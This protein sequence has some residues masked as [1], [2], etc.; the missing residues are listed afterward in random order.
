MVVSTA[1]FGFG[2][3]G[4]YLALRSQKKNQNIRTNLALLSLA[5]A[6]S[7]FITFYVINNVPFQ[8]WQ[9]HEDPMQFA[10]LAVWY[11]ALVFPFFLAGLTVAKILSHYKDHCSQLYGVDL[12]GAA[13]GSLLMVPLIS[14]IGGE[15]ITNK[16]RI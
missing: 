9:F 8:M 3:S 14:Q 16:T 6:A 5:T 2:L 15:E 11:A 13:L 1:L 10:Y 7:V 4:V 12:L